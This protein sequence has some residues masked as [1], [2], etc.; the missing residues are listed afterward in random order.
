MCVLSGAGALGCSSTSRQ[1]FYGKGKK[2]GP[3]LVCV[4]EVLGQLRLVSAAENFVWASSM[5]ACAK[6]VFVCVF[7][8]FSGLLTEALHGISSLPFGNTFLRRGKKKKFYL[9]SLKREVG[10]TKKKEDK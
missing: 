9:H 3:S 10:A 6:C 5:C 7:V 4:D 1:V 2:R 8:C